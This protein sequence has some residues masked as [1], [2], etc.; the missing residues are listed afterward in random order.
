M[1][2]S[3]ENSSDKALEARIKA[4]LEQSARNLDA[5]TQQRLNALRRKALNQPTKANWFKLNSWIPATSLA[6]CSVIAMLILIPS[7]QSANNSSAL[8]DQT[9][10][11][12]LIDYPDELDALSDPDFYLWVEEVKNENSVQHAV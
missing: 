12:E 9:A 2:E 6:F 10:L 4:S 8:T 11:L 7:H 1:S 5:D 3:L